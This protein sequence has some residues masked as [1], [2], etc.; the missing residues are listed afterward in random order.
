MRLLFCLT[1][2]SLLTACTVANLP[3]WL[4]PPDQKLFEQGMANLQT[5]EVVPDDLVVLQ[6][7]YPDSSWVAKAKTIQSLIETI[8]KQQKTVKRLKAHQTASRTR[9]EKLQQQIESLESALEVLEAERTKLRQLL[10]DL[11]QRGR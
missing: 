10:I 9:N 11:E 1:L 2:I 5:A 7:R 3:L 8:Q 6:Q 4:T